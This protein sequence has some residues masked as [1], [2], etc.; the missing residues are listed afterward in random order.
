MNSSASAFILMHFDGGEG[1]KQARGKLLKEREEENQLTN[2]GKNPSAWAKAAIRSKLR[3]SSHR[4]DQG[5][6]LWHLTT[7]D[8]AHRQQ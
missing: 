4:L 3:K 2:T 6:L 7:D 8:N 5:I 1:G